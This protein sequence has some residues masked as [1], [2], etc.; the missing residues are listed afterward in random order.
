MIEGS[1]ATART[2]ASTAGIDRGDDRAA[3]RRILRRQSGCQRDRAAGSDRLQS[4][5][6]DVDLAQQFVGERERP[7][8]VRQLI[9]W[10]EARGSARADDSVQLAHASEQRDKRF[11]ILDVDMFI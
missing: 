3:G 1:A 6:D 7:V 5:A 9:P 10:L 11:R 8:L 2:N 4:V